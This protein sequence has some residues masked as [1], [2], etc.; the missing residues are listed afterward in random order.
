MPKLPSLMTA[1]GLALLAATLSGCGGA[2]PPA[3]GG[4]IAPTAACPEV[5]GVELPPECAPYDGE[6]SMAQNERYRER[7][8]MT[9]ADAA[10][11]QRTLADA[12]TALAARLVM[13]A[14]T[15]QSVRAAFAEAGVTDVQTRVQGSTVLFGAGVPGGCIVGSAG[16]GVESLTIELGGFILD[17]GCL[18][19]Q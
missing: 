9:D 5:E 4:S 15:E 12:Q 17:G 1:V 13:D 11:N 8:E 18:P 7:T 14:A 3:A 2:A 19:A 6:A 10:T 16:S